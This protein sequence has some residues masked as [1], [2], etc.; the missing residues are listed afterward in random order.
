MRGSPRGDSEETKA[1][2][3]KAARELFAERGM[4]AT[5]VREIAA[6]AGVMHSLVHRY[7]GTKEEMAV[8]IIRREVEALVQF[9]PPVGADPAVHLAGLRK[10]LLSLLGEGRTTLQLVV[11]AEIA[12]L[13]PERMLA[14]GTRPTSL[15]AEWIRT[16]RAGV[17]ESGLRGDD[18]ALV[19]AV[20][21]AALL[22]FVTMGPWVL[23]GVG[24]L[25]E[26]FESREEEM[27]DILVHLVA[28]AAGIEDNQP[29]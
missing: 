29:G 8:E 20:V 1:L 28:E 14:S 11:Q 9:V 26:D 19:A 2:I 4:R 12:G 18:P 21:N 15:L 16:R 13:Q 25:P 27:V 6:K 10:A 3:L 23:S 22:S 5:T 7:F 24:I 17:P